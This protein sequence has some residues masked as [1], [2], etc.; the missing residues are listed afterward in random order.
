[1][2]DSDIGGVCVECGQ[3]DYLPYD[4]KNCG[5][6][7]CSDCFQKHR[8]CG[9]VIVDPKPKK[10]KRRCKEPG[11]D[12]VM[13]GPLTIK[14][15]DCGRKICPVHRHLHYA[16]CKGRSTVKPKSKPKPKHKPKPIVDIKRTEDKKRDKCSV[17]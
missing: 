12:I 11:C 7:L 10:K 4:C 8:D 14:C 6:C 16:K 3:R 1:M 17:M 5:K 13:S 2:M 15:N 9:S